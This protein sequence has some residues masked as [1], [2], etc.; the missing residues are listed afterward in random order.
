MTPYEIV[1][2]VVCI[3]PMGPSRASMRGQKWVMG[4]PKEWDT[5][6]F[7]EDFMEWVG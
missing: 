7:E 3:D 6:S 2:D 1:L 4:V 5:T